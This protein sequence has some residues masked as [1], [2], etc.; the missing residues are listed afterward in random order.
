LGDEDSGDWGDIEAGEGEERERE[1]K[2]R[3][4]L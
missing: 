4:T 1:T 3:L 2:I